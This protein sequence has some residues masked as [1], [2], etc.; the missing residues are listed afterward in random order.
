MV[1]I[2]CL[3]WLQGLSNRQFTLGMSVRWKLREKRGPSP[4]IKHF[5]APFIPAVNCVVTKQQRDERVL[6][7]LPSEED[8]VFQW[9]QD[10]EAGLEVNME[11]QKQFCPGQRTSVYP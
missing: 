1:P 4:K 11:I 5:A 9:R 8:R 3:S 7:N 10:R 2:I 6:C